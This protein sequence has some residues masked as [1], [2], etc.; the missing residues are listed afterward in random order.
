MFLLKKRAV[1]TVATVS[2][3][4]YD[5]AIIQF[6]PI[7]VQPG[8]TTQLLQQYVCQVAPITTPL[9]LHVDSLGTALP[10]QPAW[11]GEQAS[12][13]FHVLSWDRADSEQILRG[14]MN[15]V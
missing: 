9:G 5:L 11:S 6:T 3:Q 1:P 14:W 4:A 7:L 8:L 12:L 2:W 15:P 13:A 10:S